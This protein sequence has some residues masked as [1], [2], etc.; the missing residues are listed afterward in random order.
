MLNS[1]CRPLVDNGLKGGVRV[2]SFTP[3]RFQSNRL[4]YL[5][6]VMVSDGD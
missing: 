4:G 6:D 2:H 3:M 1:V 5:H